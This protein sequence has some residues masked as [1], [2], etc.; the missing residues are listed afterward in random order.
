AALMAGWVQNL[1]VP[2]IGHAIAHQFGGYGL[3]HGL[4]A[5][6]LL[7]PAMQFN[8][9]EAVVQMR[10]QTLAKRVGLSSD[11]ALFAVLAQLKK[12]LGLTV[13]D[14]TAAAIRQAVAGIY[15]GARD[16]ICAKAN[17]LPF[18]QEDVSWM[19]NEAL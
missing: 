14:E 10:Y 12:E 18:T 15:E 9:E 2:G 8:A 11:E 17:P 5:G 16:D 13:P 6:V 7:V 4:A 19:L 1:K 3:S